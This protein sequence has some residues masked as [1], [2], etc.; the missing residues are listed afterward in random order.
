M[1]L[2]AEKYNKNCISLEREGEQKK[3]AVGGNNSR[4]CKRPENM[5]EST[6]C[7]LLNAQFQTNKIC[8]IAT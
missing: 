5:S 1:I 4:A 3:S 8:F 2:Q 7:N 6:N